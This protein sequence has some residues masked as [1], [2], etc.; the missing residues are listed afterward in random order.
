LINA[1][2]FQDVVQKIEGSPTSNGDKPVKKIV[3][4]DCGSIEVPE[5]Y[6]VEQK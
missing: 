2:Y 1:F 6:A 4:K 5:P 3:I